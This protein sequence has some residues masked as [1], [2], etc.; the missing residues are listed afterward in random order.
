MIRAEGVRRDANLGF[1]IF[2]GVGIHAKLSFPFQSEFE[3]LDSFLYVP[4]RGSEVS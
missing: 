1:E 3:T 2:C 4:F